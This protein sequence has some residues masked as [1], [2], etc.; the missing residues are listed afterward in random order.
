MDR[1]RSPNKGY[2][3]SYP[4]YMVLKLTMNFPGVDVHIPLPRDDRP[5]WGR[6]LA[7]C[8]GDPGDDS[9]YAPLNPTLPYTLHCDRR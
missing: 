4:T 3:C 1:V 5:S 2:S 9:A 6:C 8:K 7:P